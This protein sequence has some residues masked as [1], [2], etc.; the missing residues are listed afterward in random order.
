MSGPVP[1]D[2]GPGLPLPAPAPH[3]AADAAADET[4][5][6]RRRHGPRPIAISDCANFYV[7]AER[8]FD[9]T[10][11]QVPVIVLS[12]NDGCAVARSE[13]AKA[14][15]IR[16]GDPLHLIRDKVEAHGVR[17]FSSNYTLYGDLS[18]RVVEVYHD[19]TPSV[20][21]YSID[22]CFL[23]LGGLGPP[24]PHA[25][26][27]RTA[28]RRRVGV[29]VRVGIAPTKTLAKCANE[30]AKKNPVFDGVLDLMDEGVRRWLLPRVPVGDV[31]GVG[32]RTEAKLHA[33]GV[34]TAA[35]LRDMPLR[36]ARMLGTVVLERLVL[37]LRGEPCLK[38]EEVEPR[39]KGLAVTRS[40]GRPMV[41]FEVVMEALTAHAT[42]AAEKLRGH[43][44]VA[45]VMTVFFHTNRHKPQAPQHGGARTL[46]LTPMTHDTLDLVAAA[47]G[48]ARAAW[49]RRGAER[50]GYTKAGVILDD[51]RPLEERPATLFDI[52][53]DGSA[54]LM[55]ALDAVN[56][57]WGR[58]TLR[59]ASEGVERSWRLRAEHRSPRYTTQLGDLPVV[60]G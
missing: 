18:R 48:G 22:E 1:R 6:G 43:G 20:E 25:R 44:L 47:R 60:R 5:P 32:R 33:L 13:Q 41:G 11:A 40:A 16:M 14:L 4:R 52:P 9:P 2:P 24:E 23:D 3:R 38:L 10:L 37:E 19:Y 56:D 42:R 8:L 51:L 35:E 12:N 15:G 30:L 45:G 34:T 46:Q 50:F 36:R 54:A 17:V 57:S 58:G 55:A 27:M 31:W 28:V 49:P 59:L 29:P 53:R 26:A 7:S 39:R 21:V